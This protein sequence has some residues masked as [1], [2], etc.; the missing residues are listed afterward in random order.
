MKKSV[1]RIVQDKNVP[2]E[3]V[4]KGLKR[5]ILAYNENMMMASV[6]FDK[7]A[8]GAMHSHPHTQVTYVRDGSF[9]VVIGS[10]NSTLRSGDSFV[11]PSGVEHGVVALEDGCL[12]DVFSPMREDLVV[13]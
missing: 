2:W 9:E 5:K 6:S 8:V 4:G 10:E 1:D 13:Q 3:D 11:V 12:V 7:G